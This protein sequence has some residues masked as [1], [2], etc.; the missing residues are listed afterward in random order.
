VECKNY[1]SEIGNPELDQLA[2]RFGQRGRLG[3][4][5]YR[6][7]GN[8]DLVFSRCRDTAMDQRGYILALDD[9]D[10]GSLVEHKLSNPRSLEFPLLRER[11]IALLS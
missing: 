2:G 3:L 8:K 9:D 1:G 11:F 7:F 5:L 10:L 4:L 6:G